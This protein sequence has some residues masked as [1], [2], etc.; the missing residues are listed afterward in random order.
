MRICLP[1][2]HKQLPLLTFFLGTC[3]L[4]PKTGDLV[5]KVLDVRR[6]VV[7]PVPLVEICRRRGIGDGL[8]QFA[9]QHPVRGRGRGRERRG[10]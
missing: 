3:E 4:L 1:Q 6:K 8:F 7:G 5:A 9:L 10:Y 2:P